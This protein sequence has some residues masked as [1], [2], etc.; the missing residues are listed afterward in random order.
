M[1]L[2]TTT[3]EAAKK[4]VEAVKD[5]MRDMKLDWGKYTFVEPSAGRGAFLEFLP[6]ETVAMD[7][8]P[9]HLGCKAAGVSDLDAG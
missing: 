3:S 4:Y 2:Y 6:S 1:D 8:L 7:I 9:Q 5:V